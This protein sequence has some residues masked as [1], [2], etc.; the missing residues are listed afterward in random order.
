MNVYRD[1]A[2]QHPINFAGVFSP[3]MATLIGLSSEIFLVG[4]GIEKASA[5]GGFA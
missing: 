4:H 2:V 3:C 5:N 1:L